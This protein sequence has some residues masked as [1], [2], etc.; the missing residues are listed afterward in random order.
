MAKVVH[1]RSLGTNC[2]YTVRG[3][4]EQEVLQEISWHATARHGVEPLAGERLKMTLIAVHDE[5]RR[6]LDCHA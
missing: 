6:C 1:C 3:E 4:T 5:G 2:D